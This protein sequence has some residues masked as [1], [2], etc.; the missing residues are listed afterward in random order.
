MGEPEV[1]SG[2]CYE[3]EEDD[4]DDES[5]GPPEEHDE[6]EIPPNA[7]N[8]SAIPTETSQIQDVAEEIATTTPQPAPQS[9]N[10]DAGGRR[11]WENQDLDFGDEPGEDYQDRSWNCDHD[12]EAYTITLAKA[13]RNDSS[14]EMECVKCWCSIHPEIQAPNATSND[15]AKVKTVPASAGRATRGLARGL[16]RGYGRGRARGRERYI[17]PRGLFQADGAIGT[18]PHL[19]TTVSSPLS[20]SV[21]TRQTSPMEDVQYSSDS[22]VDTY[23]NIIATSEI[24]LR[25]RVS[26]EAFPRDIVPPQEPTTGNVQYTSKE[27]STIFPT[28]ITTKFS[29]AHECVTCGMLVC[30]SCRNAI[31]ATVDWEHKS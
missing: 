21:P 12:F 20:Q 15:Q 11:Y 3:Y 5:D 2:N 13:L 1:C 18:A 14:T 9:R 7:N 27:T 22:V 29:L 10:L 4:D 16:T 24:E 17:P 28:T 19:T 8:V 26:D 25:R 31:W 23:G 6:D 30:T